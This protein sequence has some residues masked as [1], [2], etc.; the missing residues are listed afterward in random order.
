MVIEERKKNEKVHEILEWHHQQLEFLQQF[1][2][3][4]HTSY[5]LQDIDKEDQ[6]KALKHEIAR[7]TT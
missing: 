2:Y 4:T 1:E 7:L 5:V 3:F 6:I